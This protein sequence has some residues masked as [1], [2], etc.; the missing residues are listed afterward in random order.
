[1]Q[2]KKHMSATATSPTVQAPPLVV[3]RKVNDVDRQWTF[4]VKPLKA[5]TGET[6]KYAYVPDK[7]VNAD[8]AKAY[9]DFFTDEEK[10]EIIGRLHRQW[11]VN[12]SE[13]ASTKAA[14]AT[15]ETD[16]YRKAFSQLV[17]DMSADGLTN[18]A[19]T[20]EYNELKADLISTL[21]RKDIAGAEKEALMVKKASR[22]QEIEGIIEARKAANK[23]DSDDEAEVD[24]T[25]EGAVVAKAA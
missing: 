10:N 23:Q 15:M 12:W 1:M 16:E 2:I 24:N 18:K 5:K 11:S 14:G 22:M 17:C 25:A 8:E 3:T 21:M 13:S 9:L 7:P 4:N 6:P 19:L 20:R